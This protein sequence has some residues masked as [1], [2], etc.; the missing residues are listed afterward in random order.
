[1][2]SKLGA[3]LFSAVFMV[4]F[5]AGGVAGIAGFVAALQKAARSGASNWVEVVFMVPFATLFPAVG[6]GAAW[7]FF[8]ILRTPASELAAKTPAPNPAAIVSTR[9]GAAARA[10]LMAVF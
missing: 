4:G 8:S 6:I 1:L 5:G 2:K 9:H 10:W 7:V 3:L